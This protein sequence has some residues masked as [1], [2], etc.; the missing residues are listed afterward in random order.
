MSAPDFLLSLRMLRRS[1]LQDALG[2]PRDGLNVALHRNRLLERLVVAADSPVQDFD[3]LPANT[4]DT[5]VSLAMADVDEKAI[6]TLLVA[7]LCVRVL[8]A[9]G[10]FARLSL[11]ADRLSSLSRRILLERPF[12]AAAIEAF[13]LALQ[14]KE[15]T[16]ELLPE[17]RLG[18]SKQTDRA[19][20]ARSREQL[21][22]VLMAVTFRH[23]LSLGDRAFAERARE[24]ALATQD[25][26]LL[27]YRP[28]DGAGRHR[29]GRQSGNLLPFERERRPSSHAQHPR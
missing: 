13:A 2:L 7:L 23:L 11:L 20:V 28:Q 14:S 17:E 24:A 16:S 8:A 15:R 4:V 1:R 9:D 22:D 19:A 3:T 27:A 21:N 29:G 5:V 25:G 10:Q 12:L 6:D 18:I 26:L